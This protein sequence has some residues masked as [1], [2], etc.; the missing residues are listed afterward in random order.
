[1]FGGTNWG[2]LGHPLGYTSYDVGSPIA[3]DRQV[4]REKYSELKLQAQ[5]LQ[6]SPAYQTSMPSEGTFGIFTNTSELVV[7]ELAPTEPGGAFY[8][9]RHSDWTSQ[10]TASYSLRVTANKR[11][12]SIPQL[13]GSLSLPGRDS[14]IHVVDYDLGGILLHYSSAEVLTWKKTLSKTV[15]VLYGGIGETHEFAVPSEL[16]LP[17]SIEGAG[18]RSTQQF[19]STI[20]QWV[21]EPGRRVVHFG[22]SLEVHLLWRNDA[23]DYW[24]VDLPKPG[25]I[26]NFVSASRNGEID[27]SVIVKAGYLIRNATISENSL[28][29][30]GDVNQTTTIEVIAAPLTSGASLYFN[31]EKVENAKFVEGRLTGSIAYS[32]P[33]ITLPDFTTAEWKYIDSLPEIQLD[34]DDQLWTVLDKTATNNTRN[35]TTP[36]SLYA[37]DYGFHSGSLIYRGHFV[38]NGNES[39]LYLSLS[40]GN[41]FGHSVWLNSTYLGSWSGDPNMAIRNQTFTLKPALQ[42]ND[43]YVI[44]ILI[45]HMGL[46]QNTYVGAEGIKEPR[47]VLDYSLSGHDSQSDIT[48]KLTGNAGGENY[49]DLS[50]GPRNEG[51]LFAERQG[52]HLPGAPLDGAQTLSPIT[53]GVE[54]VGVGFYAHTFELKVPQGYDIP[55]SFVFKNA[56]LAQNGTQAPAYRAQ[57]FV[58]GWQFGEYGETNFFAASCMPL[59]RTFTNPIIVNNIGPQTSYPVP[60]GILN[61]DGENYLA[62]TLWSLETGG[63][64]LGGLSLV[65]GAAVQGGYTKPLVVQGETYLERSVF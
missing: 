63:A 1:M 17:S 39:S 9:V 38:A 55:M 54:G 47:G 10:D 21:V 44:T 13:G 58:N 4:N 2:N 50:R 26:G 6:A 31:D 40:G 46:T 42:V 59:Q 34:Y 25:P 45:D 22:E 16:G 14:K 19:D 61:Y 35:L 52:Y 20:I 7:T 15:L 57:L 36:A 37:S 56:S 8:I 49:L 65:M 48:W 3:E 62:V 64:K 28:R 41:A 12:V 24:V 11:N 30:W 60:E 32:A 51:A 53:H 33:D 23:Y 5:F 18:I 27:S 43:N 29:L